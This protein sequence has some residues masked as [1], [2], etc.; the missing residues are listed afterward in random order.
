MWVFFEMIFNFFNFFS[1]F[2]LVRAWLPLFG[3]I[4]LP[5]VINFLCQ[6]LMV[7]AGDASF[8]NSF[9]NL[10]I[11]VTGLFVCSNITAHLIFSSVVKAILLVLVYLPFS[12][13]I[14]RSIL[15]TFQKNY[16]YKFG[17]CI[18]DVTKF[19]ISRWKGPGD[20]IF[21]NRRILVNTLYF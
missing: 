1:S 19:Q 16:H 6:L 20:T 21:Y 4:K 2:R 13:H 18:Y 14:A 15:A 7:L 9:L 5:V 8:L 17:T 12:L 10:L 3:V 11:I